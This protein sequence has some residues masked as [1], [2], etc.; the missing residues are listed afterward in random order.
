MSPQID[1]KIVDITRTPHFETLL[2]RCLAPMPAKKYRQRADY[3]Q[4]AIPNGLRKKILILNGV[5]VG[6]IEYAPIEGSGYPIYGEQ[7]IVL[8]CLWVL[9]KAKGYRLG[10]HLMNAMFQEHKETKAFVTIGLTE[11]WSP[12]LKKDHMELYNFKT[13]ESI[14]VSHRTKHRDD[15]FTIHL[16]WR[17][18]PSANQQPTWNTSKLLEGITFCRAHPLYHPQH[19]RM[20]EILKIC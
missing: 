14:T 3:L 11:H 2:Y 13:V 17:P 16:M 15:C 19:I 10:Q 9:R 5:T 6:Q 12:W 8:H 20:K 4:Q 1:I 18:N 7:M